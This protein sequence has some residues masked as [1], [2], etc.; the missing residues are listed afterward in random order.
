MA[1]KP[2][3]ALSK[4]SFSCY[5]FFGYSWSLIQWYLALFVAASFK[6]HFSCDLYF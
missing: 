2:V 5:L 3:E 6:G 1:L 4:K